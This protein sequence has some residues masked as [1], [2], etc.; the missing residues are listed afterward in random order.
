MAARLTASMQVRFVALF[1]IPMHASKIGMLGECA[2]AS[3]LATVVQ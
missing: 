2:L 3:V 1:T